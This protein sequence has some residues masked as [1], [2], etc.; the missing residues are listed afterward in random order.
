MARINVDPQ[1]WQTTE[2]GLKLKQQYGGERLMMVCYGSSSD[3]PDAEQDLETY[4]RK[5]I[6][7]KVISGDY[8][9][10]P[11]AEGYKL[12]LLRADGRK[13]PRLSSTCY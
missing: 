11:D 13:V 2:A 5:S 9:V 3:A 4:M 6:Y 1:T 7:D 8:T 10:S 12:V